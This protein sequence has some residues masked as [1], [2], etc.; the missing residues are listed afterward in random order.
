MNTL[1]I[2]LP[3][4]WPKYVRTAMLHAV[5][6]AHYAVTQSRSWAADSLLKRVQLKAE[7]DRTTEQLSILKETVRIKDARM[8]RIPPH[9]RPRYTGE[10]RM[11]ILELRASQG[12][13]N[14]Q[15]SRTFLVEPDTI[16]SWMKRIE[17]RGE[18]A[19]VQLP[20]IVSRFPEFV[21][22]VVRRLKVLCPTL[23]KKR[24]ADILSRA[25]FHLSVT[26]VR[27]M[28]KLGPKGKPGI[29]ADSTWTTQPSG[30]DPVRV[31]TAE[32]P[33]HL[34][35]VDLTTVPARAGFWVPWFPFTTLQMW[36]FCWW[37]CFVVDHFSRKVVGFALFDSLPTSVQIRSVLGRAIH[38]V[39]TAPKYLVCDKGKQFFCDSFKRWCRKRKIRFRYGA[40]GKYGSIAVIERF[41]R[42]FK[43]ECTRRILV[44]LNNRKMREE[45][46]LYVT[47]YNEHRPHRTFGGKTSQEVYSQIQPANEKA[48]FE[49]RKKWPGKSRC[50]SPQT[51]VQGKPGT[52]FELLISFLGGRKHLPI[53]ELK[54]AA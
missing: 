34:W 48:R 41:I 24:I 52:R 10:E 16:S 8:S 30:E 35:H 36:P 46:A 19:L 15:T 37:V 3:R 49:P 1:S 18:N 12:W 27:R 40:V 21:S 13:S 31:V 22:Y 44:P 4:N 17:E 38:R 5:S 50:A 45:T 33:N 14:T 11:A 32:Y 25:A 43:D 23:G 51:P 9:R 54:K 47:W 29:R 28:L 20:E 7:L 2:P 39:G 53:V 26:T 6:L 42:S